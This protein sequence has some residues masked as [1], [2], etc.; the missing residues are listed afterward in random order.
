MKYRLIFLTK[1]RMKNIFWQP[2]QSTYI[3]TVEHLEFTDTVGASPPPRRH[4]SYH[5]STQFRWGKN[6]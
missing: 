4:H 5:H 2:F 3:H 6:K 1:K